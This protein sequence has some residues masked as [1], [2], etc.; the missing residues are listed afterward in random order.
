V[1][2]VDMPPLTAKLRPRQR[3]KKSP[4]LAQLL[5]PAEAL[6]IALIAASRR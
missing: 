3:A 2:F 4:T 5:K 1:Q 6:L